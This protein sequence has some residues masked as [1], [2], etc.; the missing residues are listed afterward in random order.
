MRS[1][2]F[3]HH[4]PA[5]DRLVQADGNVTRRMPG[6][7]DELKRT[8]LHVHGFVSEINGN[9][10]VDGFAKT[11]EAEELFTSILGESRLGEKRCET[12]SSQCQVSFMMRDGL[13]IKFMDADHRPGQRAH[14]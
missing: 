3:H 5:K 6:Q 8:E 4:I 1:H 9:G 10:L 11:V 14:F 12:P 7:M 13:N 2:S